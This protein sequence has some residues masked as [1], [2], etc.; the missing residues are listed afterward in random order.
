MNS[1]MSGLDNM[2]STMST[3]WFDLMPSRGAPIVVFVHL[4]SALPVLMFLCVSPVPILC[5][6]GSV[7]R[8]SMF[9]CVS[10]VTMQFRNRSV[11]R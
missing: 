7:F 5:S 9:L 8:M 10:P 2:R 11:S 6:T 1:H 3:L 4:A